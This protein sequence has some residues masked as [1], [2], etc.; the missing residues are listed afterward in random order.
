MVVEEVLPDGVVVLDVVLDGVLED[1]G[2]VVV[3][4]VVPDAL[5][6]L[7]VVV[8]VDD[9]E[10]DGV[11]GTTTVVVE[12]GGVVELVEDGGVCCWHAPSVS[13]TLAATAE[14]VS[15]VIVGAPSRKKRVGDS[16][17]G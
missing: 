4:V 11:G 12:L 2:I 8:V 13:S 14:Y 6:V 9:V 17:L 16:P 3:L 10:D 7:G 5:S 15:R 1:D